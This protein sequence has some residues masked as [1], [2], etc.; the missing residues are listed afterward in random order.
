MLAL[1][2]MAIALLTTRPDGP[3]GGILFAI[4]GV[5]AILPAV[6]VGTIVVSRLPDNRIGWLLLVAGL[7]FAVSGGVSGL[8][9]YG[10]TVHPGT[11]PGAIWLAW[12]NGWIALPMVLAVAYLLL[13]FPTGRLVSRRW[14]PVAAAAALAMLVGAAQGALTPFAPGT[15]PPDVQNPFAVSGPIGDFLSQVGNVVVIVV[16]AVLFLA[17]GSLVVRYRRAIGVERQQLKWVAATIGIAGPALAIAIL[18]SG[19][20][21]GIIGAVSEG[22]WAIA[23]ISLALLPVAIGIAVLRYRLYEIDRIISRTIAY[24]TVLGVL[25][26]V[27]AAAILV[28]QAVL[29]QVT[30]GSTVAVAASTLL[31][32]GLFQPLR[33]RVKMR[34]DRRFNRA[35]YD[36]ERTVASFTDR[37]RN[38]VQLDQLGVEIAAIVVRTVE[39]VS[40]SLW[41]R[42]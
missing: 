37:L 25:V 36:A 19:E 6:T 28:L 20:T 29:A 39:P 40:V 38:E 2:F 33:R 12:L 27:F 26:A 8:A 18:T 7:L 9:D 17:L 3:N 5:L 15:Y 24:A 14:R 31:V 41:L 11:V 4:A 42:T 35:R 22:T 1:V 16:I 21:S 34:V 10:L 32:Y 30:G 13:L 23:I